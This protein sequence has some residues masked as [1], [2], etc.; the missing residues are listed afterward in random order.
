MTGAYEVEA[1]RRGLVCPILDT[2]SAEV[3]GD[4]GSPWGCGAEDAG[5]SQWRVSC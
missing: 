2:Q 5:C 1:L 4:R 3:D